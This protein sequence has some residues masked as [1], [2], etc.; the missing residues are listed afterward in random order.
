MVLPKENKKNFHYYYTYVVQHGKRDLII[1][2]LKKNNIYCKI[3]YPFPVHLMKGYSYLKYK[4]GDFPVTERFSKRIFSLPMYPQLN[5]KMILK[6][7]KCLK[8][9]GA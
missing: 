4:R 7:T 6:I 1:K 5:R 3:I 2:K 9:A 8:K